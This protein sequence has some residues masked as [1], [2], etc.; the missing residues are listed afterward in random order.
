MEPKGDLQHLEFDIPSR[1]LIGLRNNM[2]TATSGQAI[3]THRFREFMPFKGRLL[4]NKGALISMEQGPATGL[5][6]IGC[7][8][9]VVSLLLQLM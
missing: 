8:I 7:K 9:E 5:R 1:G 6:L 4:P 2:L 3:M